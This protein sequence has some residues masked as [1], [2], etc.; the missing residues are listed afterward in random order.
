[1]KTFWTFNHFFEFLVKVDLLNFF[2]NNLSKLKFWLS[3]NSFFITHSFQS[4]KSL[5]GLNTN[6]N[7]FVK[8][9]K[10]CEYS[11]QNALK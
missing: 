6:W 4:D 5:Q 2:K 9:L 3:R 7:C 8:S 10:I 11:T 1:M